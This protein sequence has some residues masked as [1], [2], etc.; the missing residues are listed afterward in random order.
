MSVILSFGDISAQFEQTL[1]REIFASGSLLL[2]GR[3]LSDKMIFQRIEDE[4]L[5]R[6]MWNQRRNHR[7]EDF[8]ESQIPRLNLR[9]MDALS[10]RICQSVLM[11]VEDRVDK[12]VNQVFIGKTW[13]IWKLRQL[14]SDVLFTKGDDYR[15][16]VL[17][18]IMED[19]PHLKKQYGLD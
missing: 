1:N 11:D 12:L 8:V 17:E 4:V 14:R 9:R 13:N 3:E 15:A 19:Y 10:H 16:V 5:N 2:I 7:L 18:Q 6:R